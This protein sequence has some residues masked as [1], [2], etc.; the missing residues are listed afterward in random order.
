MEKQ[1]FSFKDEMKSLADIVS[2]ERLLR[3]KE[4]KEEE[5]KALA[6]EEEKRRRKKKIINGESVLSKEDDIEE[7]KVVQNI[8]KFEWESPDIVKI[9]F[10]K[11]T[12]LVLLGG[13]LLLILYFAILG[14][15]SLMLALMSL[16]FLIYV[17]GTAE[18][19]FVKYQI[20]SRG[21]DI[22]SKLYEWYMLDS[23]Y[24]TKKEN[25]YFFFVETKLRFPPSLVFIIKEE[26]KDPLFV[27]LQDKLL[28][29]DI[30]KQSRL[31]KIS[32]GE[33][34]PLEKV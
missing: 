26:D 16:V 7:K 29:K 14:H 34:I 10:S 18:P 1:K 12:F 27:I 31:S 3:E 20:T 23:F 8:K 11:K 21:V 19:R 4:E 13:S 33:Y 15:Y 6:K 24:F 30:R 25:T 22:G 32:Y 5:R 28:Y 17:Y 9:K 2:G